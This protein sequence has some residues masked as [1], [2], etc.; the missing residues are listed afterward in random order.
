MF[1]P[2]EIS[3]K[4]LK[5]LFA[6][7]PLKRITGTYYTIPAGLFDNL[8]CI[9]GFHLD[10]GYL[11]W[12]EFFRSQEYYQTKTLDDSYADF[13]RQFEI[14]FGK[15]H[16]TEMGSDGY[17]FHKWTFDNITIAHSVYERFGFSEGMSIRRD[18][19]F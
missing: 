8:H 17:H 13:Q 16:H 9:V 6:D 2:W 10:D 15:P 7:T 18:G 3:A 14:V 12:F 11:N 4:K 19:I 5:R 1:V